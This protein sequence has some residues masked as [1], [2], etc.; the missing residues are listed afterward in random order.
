V[1]YLLV[2]LSIS[3]IT[4]YERHLLGSSQLRYGPNKPIFLGLVVPFFDGLKLFQ[5]EVLKPY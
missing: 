1:H 3:Y 4:L 5:K 2:L